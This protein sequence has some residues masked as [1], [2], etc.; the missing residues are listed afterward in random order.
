[1]KDAEAERKATVSSRF[2]DVSA[3]RRTSSV[4]L[5]SKYSSRSSMKQSTNSSHK[6][7]T[8]DRAVEEKIKIVGID[9]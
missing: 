8:E 9:S 2:S 3:G 5:I 1:M 4:R 6:Y 7:S